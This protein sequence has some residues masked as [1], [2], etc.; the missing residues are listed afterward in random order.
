MDLG[1]D[2]P[3][4][5]LEFPPKSISSFP[6][7]DPLLQN[8]HLTF[9]LCSASQMKISQNFVAFSEYMNFILGLCVMKWGMKKGGILFVTLNHQFIV[10][11]L[12]IF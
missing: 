1:E 10:T 11:N 12:L 9:V 7:R 4:F 5:E 8:L 3:F 6:I 2:S